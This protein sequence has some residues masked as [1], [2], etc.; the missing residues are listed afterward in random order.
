[1][2]V[3]IDLTAPFDTVS[4]DTLISK[5]AGSS[6]P[7]AITRWLSCYPRGRQSATN[8][9]GTKSSTRIVR[10]GVP[11]GSTL[12]PSQFNYYIA[13]MLSPTPPVKRVFYADDITVWATGPRIPQLESMI[14]SYLRDVATI[15]STRGGTVGQQTTP[16]N[17]D[18]YYPD[19]LLFVS[20]G[21][22]PRVKDQ[23]SRCE[24]TLHSTTKPLRRRPDRT[25]LLLM[26][27]AIHPNPGPTTKYP[28]PVCARDVTSRGVSYRCTRCTGWVHAKCSGL[29]NAAQYR[30]NNDRTWD[31]W[32]ASKTQQ[33][34]PPPPSPPLLHLPI[35]LVMT[36][37]STV[38]S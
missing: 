33:P 7:P 20:A 34:T 15:S 25:Q 35:K 23:F 38:Q 18:H 14:N 21:F 22:L 19:S 8:F 27:G 2:C 26:A 12:S 16:A 13:N 24:L 28:C 32:S 4:H 11:Q 30:R 9:R 1:M 3:A 37:R 5:I 31:P 17:R 6:L 29:L 10:T 36:A